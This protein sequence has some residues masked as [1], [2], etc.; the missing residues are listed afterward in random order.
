MQSQLPPRHQVSENGSE[1]SITIRNWKVKSRKLPI[2]S[3]K[4]IDDANSRLGIP[5]PEMIFGNN[6]V[7]IEHA[8]GWA[9]KFDALDALD[10]VDKTG[11]TMLKV[12]YSQEWNQSRDTSS[13]DIKDVVKPYDWTY[14]TSYKGTVVEGSQPFSAT[15]DNIP[16]DKLK[17]PDPILFYDEADLYEDELHDNGASLLNVRVRVMPQRMLLLARLFMRLDGVVCRIRDTRVYVDF[18][19]DD[20]LREYTAKE[21]SY[22]D[23]KRR[24]PPWKAEETGVLMNDPMWVAEQLKVVENIKETVRL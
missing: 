22:D 18:E 10:M 1:R 21:G 24:V 23:V 8:S 20:V 17:Q 4:E 12:A 16:L 11:E 14:T 5:I 13:G 15:S 6:E 9:I 19:T 2:L 7:R 3:S